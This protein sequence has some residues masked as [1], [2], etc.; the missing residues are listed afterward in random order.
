MSW[1]IVLFGP[2]ENAEPDQLQK[3][4]ARFNAIPRDVDEAVRYEWGELMTDS[5]PFSH[6]LFLT[7]RDPNDASG[8]D[9]DLHEGVFEEGYRVRTMQ[10]DNVRDATPGVRGSSRGHLRRILK[11][12]F[13][14]SDVE[15]KR[16]LEHV[17]LEL[18]SKV[19]SVERLQWGF[20]VHKELKGNSTCCVVLTFE[21][22]AARDVCLADPDFTEFEKM[23][24]DEGIYEYIAT[25]DW[26][27]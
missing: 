25:D 10:I 11:F 8:L 6:C 26:S 18:P 17:M 7:L 24:D 9:L 16:E 15:S 3:A 5:A 2:R 14:V 1:Y 22:P 4:S 13:D 20:E 12:P 19:P 27:F 23:Y 21:D